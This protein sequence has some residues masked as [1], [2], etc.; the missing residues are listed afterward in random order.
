MANIVISK[1]KLRRGTR[2][3]IKT[4]I[5]DQGEPIYSID[6]DR[7]Y[8]GTSTVSGGVVVGSKVHSQVANY[9][10]LSAVVAEVGDIV[11][12]NNKFYQLTASSYSDLTSWRD[13]A[14]KLDPR[15]LRYDSFNR[16]AIQPNSLSAALL[17]S[18]T[19]GNGIKIETNILQLDY[20]TKSLEI[21]G[22][23]LSVKA[24]GID[25]REISTSSLSYGLS[26]GS[27]DKLQVIANYDY[28]YFDGTNRLSLST[29]PIETIDPNWAGNGISINTSAALISATLANVD[30]NTL[31]RSDNGTISMSS[32]TV[33]SNYELGKHTID[34][35]GRV[36]NSEPAIHDFLIGNSG[37]SSI[38][39]PLSAIFNGSPLGITLSGV[40]VTRFTALSSD[41][42]TTVTL[43]SGGYIVF[44][45]NTTTRNSPLSTIPRFAIPIFLF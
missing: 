23:Q 9:N 39:H 24:D 11:E 40:N 7:L 30:N 34:E 10:S 32:I 35:Y 26:G 22:G 36:T 20:T 17:D 29:L 8:I 31:A 27:G 45:G 2:D 43:S 3:E 37:L 14:A 41:G 33:S 19:V 15:V 4:V 6:T 18:S 5:F 1:I 13:V 12:A 25:E 42:V 16:I 21:S 38:Y 44:E 28:F